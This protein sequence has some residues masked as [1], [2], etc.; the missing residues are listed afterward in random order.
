MMTSPSF[1]EV[2]SSSKFQLINSNIDSGGMDQGN[3][4]FSFKFQSIG[5]LGYGMTKDTTTTIISGPYYSSDVYKLLGVDLPYDRSI[6]PMLAQDDGFISTTVEY[7]VV[8]DG[9]TQLLATFYQG[10]EWVAEWNTWLE[11]DDYKE[12]EI[13]ARVFDGLTWGGWYTTGAFF[14]DNKPPEIESLLLS[15]EGLEINSELGLIQGTWVATDNISPTI[16]MQLHY[17]SNDTNP[18]FFSDIVFWLDGADEYYL[19]KDGSN[20]VNQWR[21]RS[22]NGHVFSQD[23]VSNEPLL[24]EGSASGLNTLYFD[25]DDYLNAELD[26]LTDK[27]MTMFLVFKAD[28]SFE[29]GQLVEW[30]DDVDDTVTQVQGS[31][32]SVGYSG[33]TLTF[34]DSVV[35]TSDDTIEKGQW[36]VLAVIKDNSGKDLLVRV[37][38]VEGDDVNANFSSTTVFGRSMS[39]GKAFNSSSQFK[40]EL[41]EAILFNSALT[42][43]HVKEI[44]SYLSHKWGLKTFLPTD[45]DDDVE[46]WIDATDETSFT[47]N[48]KNLFLNSIVDKG[49]FG[50]ALSMPDEQTEH[51]TYVSTGERPYFEFNAD[52]VITYT[53]G[54]LEGKTTI[55]VVFQNK[56]FQPNQVLLSLKNDSNDSYIIGVNPGNNGNLAIHKEGNRTVD[57]SIEYDFEIG[58]WYVLTIV[59]D[60]STMKWYVDGEY[61]GE[62]ASSTSDG[63]WRD[64]VIGALDE[65]GTNGYKGYIGELV[66]VNNSVSKEDLYKLDQSLIMKWKS[67][68]YDHW[69]SDTESF[70]G[71]SW[72]KTSVND[73]AYHLIK[74]QAEDLAGNRAEL[75]SNS[76]LTPD[77]TPPIIGMIDAGKII[78][79]LNL[80]SGTEDVNFA[81]DLSKY[82]WDD[83]EGSL[84]WLVDMYTQNNSNPL[85]KDSYKAAD[86]ILKSARLESPDSDILNFIVSPNANTGDSVDGGISP[87]NKFGKEA[88]YITLN[89]ADRYGNNVTKDIRVHIQS[90]NDAPFFTKYV[91]DETSYKDSDNSILY[92]AKFNEDTTFSGL[93]LEDFVEDF[94]TPLSELSFSVSGN[95][96]TQYGDSPFDEGTLSAYSSPELDVFIGN[97][98]SGFDMRLVPSGNWYGESSYSILVT[99]NDDSTYDA[100]PFI[101]RV[102]PQ[103]DNPIIDDEIPIY[104]QLEEDNALTLDFTDYEDD[105]FME[106][107]AP[108]YGVNLNWDVVSYDPNVIVSIRGESSADDIITFIPTD[109]Y[110]GTTNVVIRLTDTDEVPQLVFGKDDPAPY[111]PDP[112]S[113]TLSVTI[114]W[115]PVNDAPEIKNLTEINIEEDSEPLS[116]D[117]SDYIYD[118]EDDLENMS[119]EVTFDGSDIMDMEISVDKLSITIN[120]L[121]NAWG[122]GELVVILT[123]SDQFIEFQPYTPNPKTTTIS[124]PVNLISVNDVPTITDVAWEGISD[125]TERL[126]STDSL[127][128]TVNGF[129]D[130]G[131]ASGDAVSAIGGEYL[132][133]TN[134]DVSFFKNT[135][136]YNFRWSL[137]EDGVTQ[138]EEVILEQESPYASFEIT[139]DMEGQTLVLDAWPSD[140]YDDGDSIRTTIPINIR[141]E[142]V[143]HNSVSPFS[144][145]WTATSSV[146]ISWDAATDEDDEPEDVG[147]KFVAW[148]VN[149]WK[150]G[151]P[152]DP[153][154]QTPDIEVSWV[155]NNLTSL[156][157]V[158]PDGHYYWT[159]YSGNQFDGTYW[160]F[161][162]ETSLY[163]MHIDTI[164]PEI[165]TADAIIYNDFLEESI[166]SGT[167]IYDALNSRVLYGSFEGV[168]NE[169][170]YSIW[171]E[172]TN[173]NGTIITYSYINIIPTTDVT[174]WT[175][176]I[177]YPEGTTTYNVYIRDNVGNTTLDKTFVIMQDTT[178]PPT[179]EISEE[180]GLVYLDGVWYGTTS[181]NTFQI[182]GSKESYASIWFEDV[183]LTGF[184]RESSFNA[185]IYP[186]KPSGNLTAKDRSE[187][188][189][190]PA[191][192]FI[193]FVL[194]NPQ[195]STLNV[196]R[197]IINS[198]DNPLIS[199]L[200]SEL[201]QTI[202]QTTITWV[203]SRDVKSYRIVT[204]ADAV[205]LSGGEV[206][207]GVSVENLI[208]GNN[209]ALSEGENTLR[210][211]ITDEAG[212]VGEE[213]FT[214][215]LFTQAPSTDVVDDGFA[216]YD[217]GAWVVDIHGSFDAY[218]TPY[219]FVNGEEEIISTYNSKTW[220]YFNP[221]FDLENDDILLMMRDVVYNVATRNIWDHSNYESSESDIIISESPILSFIDLPP[222][223]MG[224]YAK[225][226]SDT[227]HQ[228]GF[229]VKSRNKALKKEFLDQSL[230]I[231]TGM[232]QSIYQIYAKDF[233]KQVLVDVSLEGNNVLLKLPYLDAVTVDPE[234]LVPVYF[235]SEESIWK[236]ME[237]QFVLDTQNKVVVTKLT[238]T[239][240]VALAEEAGFYADLASV[241]VY[242]N[243]F[244]PNDNNDDTGTPESGITFDQ[245]SENTRI[246]IY[247]LTGQLVADGVASTESSWNWDVKNLSGRPVSSGVYIYIL[248]SGN[249][250]KTGKLT[251]IR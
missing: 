118:V 245:L 193:N 165:S 209:S 139:T 5:S 192:I 214:I 141:P 107:I 51:P 38:G 207:A 226:V 126:M 146:T 206:L 59:D 136:Y 120:A 172:A 251:I 129:A 237:G 211:Q 20:Y 41:A 243:P 230:T 231:P 145:Y 167:P 98:A 241:R 70:T 247:T 50:H 164:D 249:N 75:I 35:G 240:I 198:P 95:H 21:D 213:E 219:I 196:S 91:E 140:G 108:E 61:L 49:R 155:T 166:E 223:I 159:L 86:S 10:E 222:G 215:R 200:D 135:A 93:R 180:S 229:S 121:A 63:P 177:D 119:L 96:F 220:R 84:S 161:N 29:T 125:N 69:E 104:V 124:I 47:Y 128:V 22:G 148:A 25:G 65:D 170:L 186:D 72:I 203:P 79:E 150:S 54:F 217:L 37:N 77:R 156:D 205:V 138:S 26:Q 109:N 81:F 225:E 246:R 208:V 176:R 242:P 92:N 204:E 34:K 244:V 17:L 44:E 60:E 8:L 201:I 179:P 218:T 102:W 55:S 144:D 191:T 114:V 58:T 18:R 173:D 7:Y 2:S 122:E 3:D 189:S 78:E 250:T 11:I 234:K 195:I 187:N 9:E 62:T 23:Q 233:G 56:F 175:Y 83:D 4:D 117:L 67:T 238:N 103:N 28:E 152:S 12:V 73:N 43:S 94:D 42:E 14:V 48:T 131:Y 212:N 19:T 99:D 40:G 151:P 178:P 221:N 168:E 158:I 16:N 188:E 185:L 115:T 66:L 24:L 183:Q 182:I 174:E 71:N 110:Y 162:N 163:F 15:A 113:T 239:N 88:A 97:A 210:L 232:E 39:L 64:G 13:L 147:Y 202:T 228:E 133:T 199:E 169:E 32:I 194:G 181:A 149:S 80:I 30:S 105:E 85:L 190:G 68:N 1:G 76:A 57:A 227:N 106:D 154:N 82:K 235:D 184:S 6:I 52:D 236:P 197:D 123:D 87:G 74:V 45:L 137:M 116:L 157:L 143:D 101:A 160:D 33:N 89:L 153:A 53:N 90:V 132:S 171:L 100:Q 134:I 112:K 111:V 46:L 36:I 224:L 31:K 27:D 130:I 216:E 142:K 127:R 248:Q